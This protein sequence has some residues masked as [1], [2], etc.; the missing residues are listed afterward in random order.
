MQIAT[1]AAPLLLAS[2]AWAAGSVWVVAPAPGLGVD[3]TSVQA[4]ANAAADSD[5][6][7]IRPGSYPVEHVVVTGKSLL[8]VGDIQ[9][10]Q[11]DAH[12]TLQASAPGAAKSW[13]LR[14]LVLHGGTSGTAA[15]DLSDS[16]GFAWIEGCTLVG[17]PGTADN[18]ALRAAQQGGLHVIG[19]DVRPTSGSA[20]DASATPLALWNSS[21][22]GGAGAL[23]GAQT[24]APGAG[25]QSDGF[26]LASGCVLEGGA[27]A[28]AG[29]GC[30]TAATDGAVGLSLYGGASALVSETT[31]F[32]GAGG[33]GG[34]LCAEGAAGA[35]TDAPGAISFNP[36]GYP[37]GLESPSPLREGE[38]FVLSFNGIPDEFAFAAWSLAP[39]FLALPEFAAV[40]GVGAPLEI[41]AVGYVQG[42][43]AV[44]L[45][46][47]ATELGAGIESAVIY[48]QP[49]YYAPFFPPGAE[50]SLGAPSA[51]VVLDRSF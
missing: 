45:T 7:L 16:A 36:F 44:P 21:T 19:C 33:A 13:L 23:L 50:W 9:F 2:S 10:G 26:L 43:G 47:S 20:I 42:G 11:V 31:L 35:E 38:T 5:V 18:G 17:E 51:I 32:G 14:N 39:D 4:A 3:F 6:I 37:R 41:F 34:G 8:F 12:F 49:I 28:P 24:V 22:H 29:A 48:A 27:G 40:L 46:L 15:V 1:F 25:V 30:A